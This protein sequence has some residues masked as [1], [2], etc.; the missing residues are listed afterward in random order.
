M[1]ADGEP[2]G[3]CQFGPIGELPIPHK[4][5]PSH[6]NGEGR[7]WRITCFCTMKDYRRQGIAELALRAA[8]DAIRRKG[9]GSVVAQPVAE[10]PHDQQLDDLIREHGGVSAEVLRHAKKQFGAT[11]VVAY[12]RRAWSV[13]GIFLHGLGPVWASVRRGAT[14]SHTGS[15]EMF[16]RA[17]FKATEVIEPTS[18]KLPLSR[19]VM[20]RTVRRS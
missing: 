16:E 7:V 17:R 10:L 14:A 6:D 13:G 2:V 18:R 5:E 4:A 15:V 12:D 20:Q 8:L 19:L 1:Y 11:D 9:G 3:W